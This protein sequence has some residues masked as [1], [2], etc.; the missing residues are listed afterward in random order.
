VIAVLV[1]NTYDPIFRREFDAVIPLLDRA[2]IFTIDLYPAVVEKFQGTP[3]ES[4]QA[5]RA[6]R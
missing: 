1:P 2:G 3:I 5:S 6:F 4:L